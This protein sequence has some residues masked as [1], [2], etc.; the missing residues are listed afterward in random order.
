MRS[1]VST[2]V[3]KGHFAQ[4]RGA[5]NHVFDEPS[6][7]WPYINSVGASLSLRRHSLLIIICAHTAGDHLAI[8]R[9]KI[10]AKS[11]ANVG[12]WIHYGP[13]LSLS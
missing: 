10:M 8:R 1:R 5:W 12:G 3:H 11:D 4:S 7:H 2:R 9:A 6:N 13:P